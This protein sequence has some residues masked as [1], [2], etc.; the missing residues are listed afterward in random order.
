M[1]AVR[2]AAYRDEIDL[3][4]RSVAVPWPAPG[5]VLIKVAASPVHFDDVVFCRGLHGFRRALPTTPGFEGAGEVVA[6]GG[7]LVTRWLVGKRVAFAVADDT[8]GAWA[9][10]ALADASRCLPLWDDLDDEQASALLVDPVTALALLEDVKEHRHGALVLTDPGGSV[11]RILVELAKREKLPVVLVASDA[12]EVARL[13]ALGLEHALDASEPD[14]EAKVRRASRAWKATA[15]LDGVGG[16]LTG[17]LLAALPEGAEAVLYGIEPGSRIEVDLAEVVYRRKAVRGF[18]F[19]DRV[20]GQGPKGLLAH[21]KLL[22]KHAADAFR[23]KVT[24]RLSLDEVP[25]AVARHGSDRGDGRV[26]VRPSLPP[27]RRR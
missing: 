25:E 23:T 14:F 15:V 27:P 24:A 2:L 13:K 17:R 12:E 26:I 6:V 18:S 4:V 8:D 20:R 19:L 3:E 5:Q 9:E 1:R 11:G 10:Y 7:G 16:E 21:Q 22:R